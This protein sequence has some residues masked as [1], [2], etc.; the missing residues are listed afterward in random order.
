[1]KR[2]E[3]IGKKNVFVLFAKEQHYNVLKRNYLWWRKV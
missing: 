1:M 3:T 2:T